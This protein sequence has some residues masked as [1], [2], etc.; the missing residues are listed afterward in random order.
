MKHIILLSIA[1]LSFSAQSQNKFEIEHCKDVMTGAEYFVPKK[2]LLGLNKEKTKGFSIFPSYKAK[3]GE[4]VQDGLICKSVG[5]G[6]CNDEDSLIFLFS[7]DTKFTITSWNK[8]NCDGN[9]YFNLT[10]SQHA[11]LSTKKLKAVRFT[12]GRSFESLTH[13]VTEIESTYFI[14]AYTNKKIVEVNCN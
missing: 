8:F 11:E 14:S 12:N 9:A 6:G 13:I 10:H 1:L 4:I 3:G 7:D 2:N 5:I